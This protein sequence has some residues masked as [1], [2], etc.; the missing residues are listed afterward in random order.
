MNLP[1]MVDNLSTIGGKFI[2]VRY[3]EPPIYSVQ[4]EPHFKEG[5]YEFVSRSSAKLIQI[6]N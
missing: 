6:I 2:D 1:P 4:I 3:I 5:F